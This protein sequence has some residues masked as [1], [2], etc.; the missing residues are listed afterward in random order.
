MF[1][2]EEKKLAQKRH[3]LD[4]LEIPEK[5]LSHA[6]RAGVAQSEKKMKRARKSVFT[7]AA[8]AVL[9]LAF[10]TSVRVSPAFANMVASLPGMSAIVDMIQSDKGMKAII[11][12]EYYEE[13]HATDSDGNITIT[14]NGVI[15][16]QSG[17]V[18]TYTVDSATGLKDPL[19]ET[20]EIYADGK[21][22]EPQ[23]IS[24]NYPAAADAR[25]SE[26][27]IDYH[28]ADP[29]PIGTT[30][31]EVRMQ[32][33]DDES[34]HFRLPFSIKKP[35]AQGK[36]FPLDRT[37]IVEGQKIIIRS[38]TIH[39][40][41]VEVAVDF[42]EANTM[43]ILQFEDMR[44]VDGK[45]ETWSSIRNGMS[46]T[47]EEDGTQIYFL[48]SNYFEKPELMVFRMNEMQAIDKNEK[49]IID[50]RL[51]K[52]IQTPSDGKLEVTGIS[53]RRIE[54]KLRTGGEFGYGYLMEATD[55]NGKPV[56]QKSGGMWSTDGKGDTFTY[57]DMEFADTDYANPITV[58]F[59]AYPN[60]IRGDVTLRLD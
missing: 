43:D 16:D 5:A 1:E 41:R 54:T 7:L 35:V 36:V 45:G 11:D 50:T 31:F 52:V 20:P 57:N 33:R 25:T 32:I 22:I 10:V 26:Q 49:L 21:L 18:I 56:D 44:I 46:A 12:N 2:E 30:E 47:E 13:V 42:D 9:L 40:L 6:I 39:P 28:F 19:F 27:L 53:P 37:V 8:V 24:W 55:S 23:G 51:G 38:I 48:Q 60:Y 34:H 29:L 4:H 15:V 58:R 3:A 14:L 17:M 59:F